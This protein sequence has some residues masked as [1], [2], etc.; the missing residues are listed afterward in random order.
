[1]YLPLKNPTKP[2]WDKNFFRVLSSERFLSN[3]SFWK[4]DNF[5]YLMIINVSLSNEN[6]RI[7]Q[8]CPT[9]P[10]RYLSERRKIFCNFFCYL[11]NDEGC[12]KRQITRNSSLAESAMRRNINNINLIRFFLPSHDFLF[13]FSPR[14]IILHTSITHR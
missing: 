12:S 3:F 8:P 5:M 1:M 9:P 2:G 13:R 11:G 7:L 14:I 10:F 4:G 6:N